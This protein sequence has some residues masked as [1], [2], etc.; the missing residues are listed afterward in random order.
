MG[1]LVNKRKSSP[2]RSITIRDVAKRAAVSVATV[3]RVLNGS[4]RVRD[5]TRTKVERI[6]R[7]LEFVPNMIASSLAKNRSECIGLIIPNLGP[8]F[9]PLVNEIEQVVRAEGSYLV[10]VTGKIKADD[11][12]RAVQFLQQRRCDALIVFPGEMNDRQVSTLLE[13]NNNVIVLHHLVAKHQERC[14]LVDNRAGARMATRYLIDCGHR[15]IAVITGPNGNYESSERLTAFKSTMEEAGLIVDPKLVVPGEF[16]PP[17]GERGVAQLLASGREVSALFCFSD[18][19]AAGAIS[20]MR[21]AGIMLPRDMSVIGFDDVLYCS[22]IFPRLTTVHQPTREIGHIAA[23]RALA[24]SSRRELPL[25]PSV[26]QPKLVVRD[27]VIPFRMLDTPVRVLPNLV[28][29][30]I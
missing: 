27:S 15:D 14:V 29:S 18:E 16:D 10:I 24:L 20:Y 28:M 23:Q 17:S 19:M 11:V 12:T 30:H 6:M 26:L 21:S 3:S 25:G 7:E 9:A 1:N 8:L 2:T 5:K 13:E 22:Q 4:S